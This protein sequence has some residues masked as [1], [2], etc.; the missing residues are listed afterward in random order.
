MVRL[1]AYLLLVFAIASGLVW[2]A[3]RPGTLNIVW[4][5]YDIETTVFQATVILAAI[6]ATCIFVLSIARQIWM[7]PASVSRHFVRRRQKRGLEALSSGMIALGAGDKALATRYALQARR[8]LP[9]EPLTHL[10]RAQ[11]AQ[12]AGDRT[13]ARRIFEAML[14]SPDTEQL[15]LRGLYLEAER[16]KE[17]E[18]AK[19]FA[20][21]ALRLNPK[22]GWPADALFDI[23]CR[24]KD[25]AGALE[26]LSVA[27]RNGL[28]D[29]A[30]GDRRRAVLLTGQA[31]ALEDS[32]PERALT[33]A[34]EAHGLAPDLIPAAAIAGRLLAAR[35]NTPRAAKII[36][37]TWS[38]SPHPELATAYAYARI[39]DSPRD[40]LDRVKQLA[41]LYPNSA[42]SAIAVA[43]SA[44]EARDWA[45]AR[46]ALEPLLDGR[47]SQR[48]CTLMARIED[49]E[50]ADK[51]GVREWLA[52]AVNA[53]RDP[54]WTA[55]G[56]VAAEWSPVSPVTGAL[57]V[58]EWKVPG[59][60]A[61][62]AGRQAIDSKIDD[63]VALGAPA[64][65][66]DIDAT[67]LP[68]IDAE[69]GPRPATQQSSLEAP[70]PAAQADTASA[71][72]SVTRPTTY[73][74]R[75]RRKP[76]PRTA[77]PPPP[78]AA[79]PAATDLPGQQ[80]AEVEF[81]STRSERQAETVSTETGING[82]EVAIAEDPPARP[83]P[84]VAGDIT[85]I[86]RSASGGR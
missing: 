80:E 17:T 62:D 23:Q 78:A 13:T 67:A 58:F 84:E 33:L 79:E 85:Y 68:E 52:R 69:G 86:R 38:R 21:R 24:L 36:Q 12:A 9:N 20:E 51:G 27:K 70:A 56:V 82:A 71:A 19:Q 55:D 45:E 18:A 7:S 57:D 77:A 32:D 34:I 76:A 2:L 29:K 81:V 64:P 72:D 10:L 3:E 35:G 59:A 60:A 66:T 75:A 83:K 40:R 4:Q 5:G 37:K 25:W 30:T 1:V 26:T 11:A 39:G 46:A 74:D 14:S 28:V 61:A 48:V 44:I 49:G 47:L 53:P 22:L 42:E 43:S 65:G 50:F 6:V 73:R 31:Q 8:S 63:L 54:A 41:T 16:E 15:G